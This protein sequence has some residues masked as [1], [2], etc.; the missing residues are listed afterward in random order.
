MNYR[1]LTKSAEPLPKG[2]QNCRVEARPL[3]GRGRQQGGNPGHVNQL[4]REV[5]HE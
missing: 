1:E 3:G 5:E 4:R 2:I